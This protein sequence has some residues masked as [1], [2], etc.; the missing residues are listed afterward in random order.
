MRTSLLSLPI[1]SLLA[2]GGPQNVN[3]EE[4]TA[5]GHRAEARKEREVGSEHVR[6]Y[7]DA[8]KTPEG[9]GTHWVRG[10][11]ADAPHFPVATYDPA[12]HEIDEANWHFTHAEAHEKAARELER[13]EE[14]ECKYFPGE[15]RAACPLLGPAVGYKELPEGV[16]ITFDPRVPA[17]A[18]GAHMRCHQAYA[19]ARGYDPGCPL[20]IKGLEIQVTVDE[21]VVHITTDDATDV[22]TLRERARKQIVVGRPRV[23]P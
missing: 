20:F 5:A 18:V 1:L 14:Q 23:E 8:Q 9:K 6:A 4:T 22:K 3:P 19:R 2:C 10:P 16:E 21:N 12:R 17:L 7:T 11:F 15:T 13:F